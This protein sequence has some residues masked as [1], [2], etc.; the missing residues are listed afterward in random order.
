[1]V[2]KNFSG[3]RGC[4]ICFLLLRSFL[5]SLMK[6]KQTA[7]RGPTSSGRP[8]VTGFYWDPCKLALDFASVNTSVWHILNLITQSGNSFSC[9]HLFWMGEWNKQC[10]QFCQKSYF[11]SC[12]WSIVNFA[13]LAWL[14]Q[15]SVLPNIV[16]VVNKLEVNLL[17]VGDMDKW[18]SVLVQVPGSKSQ[19]HCSKTNSKIT[20]L[21]DHT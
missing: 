15:I 17:V 7:V 21:L 2:F 13:F 1:M 12:L 18:F 4:F 6:S 20:E 11:N 14:S 19:V 5:F 10:M 16:I 8:L 3:R 9:Y